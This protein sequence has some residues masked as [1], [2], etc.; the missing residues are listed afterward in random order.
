MAEATTQGAH[1]KELIIYKYN[2]VFSM[3]L[4][5]F[6][7]V[8]ALPLNHSCPHKEGAGNEEGKGGGQGRMTCQI[9]TSVATR[10]ACLIIWP[11]GSPILVIFALR[12]CKIKISELSFLPFSF[13]FVVSNLEIG[14]AA[15]AERFI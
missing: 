13:S 2:L 6:R 9:Q 15:G 7:L 12:I 11:R 14:T 8:G 1:Q 3:L 4:R 5:I 10:S